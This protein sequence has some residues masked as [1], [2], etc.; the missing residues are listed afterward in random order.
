MVLNAD[1]GADRAS[2]LVDSVELEEVE[3][4]RG[5]QLHIFSVARVV[6]G[7]RYCSVEVVGNVVA[8]VTVGVEQR[9]VVGMQTL[10]E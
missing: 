10:S 9:L 3:E 8:M 7:V 2:Y 1:V 4:L 5:V 6:D